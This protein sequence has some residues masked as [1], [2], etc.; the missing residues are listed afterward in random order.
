[1]K[2]KR[3]GLFLILIA[4]IAGCLV[5]T[6]L[7]A[8]SI[9]T[10]SQANERVLTKTL[11]VAANDAIESEINQPIVT[12][13][14]MASNSFL[15]EALSAEDSFS[16][17]EMVEKMRTYLF[18]VKEA[19]GADTAF[20][21]SEKSKRY[22]T[23]EGLNKIIDPV[24]DDHDIWYSIFVDGRRDYDLDVDVDEV[25]DG[26]WTVFINCRIE[27]TQGKLLGACGVG[28]RMDNLQVLLDLY[29]SEYDLKINLVDGSG[30]VQVDTDSINIE[31]AYLHNV[32]YDNEID[33]YLYKLDDNNTSSVTKYIEDL[34]WYLV[35][36]KDN[37][38]S[39]EFIKK[40]VVSNLAVLGM[41]IGII[42]AIW[43]G[44]MKENPDTASEP[45]SK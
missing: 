13:K 29:E 35:V 8:T 1:M 23:Y 19:I 9:K 7:T 11:A 17:E 3:G 27:D 42:V 30:L 40:L 20:V 36:Q 37:R 38:A 44:F 45:A 10:K 25:N 18:G 43:I 6:Y 34:G 14:A 24:H 28:V 32:T 5:T 15:Q 41:C 16:E 33:G 21:V 31:N 4:V 39:N 22:Y 26:C 12:G 2:N